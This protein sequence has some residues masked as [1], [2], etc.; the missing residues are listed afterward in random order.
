ME[1]KYEVFISCKS[2]DYPL[3]D[4]VYDYLVKSDVSV[5][6]AP[7]QLGPLG[8][9]EYRKAIVEAIENSTNMIV[10][11]SQL[12]YLQSKWVKYESGLFISGMLDGSVN[13]N[14]V[15]ILKDID[16]KDVPLDLRI[17]QSLDY[18]NYEDDVLNYL[19]KKRVPPKPH[20][21]IK[22]PEWL[23]E[24][25]GW[26]VIVAIFIMTYLVCFTS[27]YIYTRYFT[28]SKS[29]VRVKMQRELVN[30]M[31]IEGAIA[32]YDNLGII[33]IYDAESN[34]VRSVRV[35]T[36]EF[37]LTQ[38]DYFRAAS[39]TYGISL[40][41]NK[42]FKNVKSSLRKKYGLIII[43]VS[44]VTTLFGISTG[45]YIAEKK[46]NA[47]FQKEMA[48]FLESP[49]NWVVCRQIYEDKKNR[50]LDIYEVLKKH[51]K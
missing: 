4:N 6:F 31:E 10:F 40:W 33:A 45:N 27:S 25:S 26:L 28:G 35:D 39:V 42:V 7:R 11:A 17:Y 14:L 32:K 46:N 37:T 49:S 51:K 41:K 20:P 48:E 24:A 5:F 13:G 16:M 22:L 2:D 43:P 23:E 15:T 34:Q 29:D 36:D 9:S 21:H 30:E 8:E 3:A 12:E 1:K 19:R 18:D 44:F 50:P 47:E 38:K